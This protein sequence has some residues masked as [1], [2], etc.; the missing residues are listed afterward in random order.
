MAAVNQDF[1]TYVG[2]AVSP[3][4]TV[5]TSSGG[6]VVDIS[7]ASEI[8]WSAYRDDASAAVLTKL[9]STGAITF[10]N[11]GTDG[12]FQVAI[13]KTDT[14]LLTGAY[15]HKATITDANGN[16]TSVAVGRMQVGLAPSWS[17][18]PTQI[19]NSALYQVRRLIGDVL[20]SDQQMQD[21]EILWSIS[22][23]G[24]VYMAAA[25]C[26]RSLSAQFAR[27]V[28]TVQGELHTLYGQ[29]TRNYLAMANKFDG[30]GMTRGSF[31][32]AYAGGIS[33]ADKQARNE[34]T[35][36]VPPQFNIGMGDNLLPI[37]PAGNEM[38]AGQQPDSGAQP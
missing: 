12:K 37:T 11:T 22:Q 19:A 24:N 10:V 35:D 33:M 25:E 34:D 18:D 9:K 7:G 27:M 26:C 32:M 21:E 2:D 31:S 14:A 36:R 5:T 8:A 38:P 23:N 3:I 4:F 1:N 6:A 17:Y 13:L 16:V 29:R 15:I 28:D 30:I 20:N